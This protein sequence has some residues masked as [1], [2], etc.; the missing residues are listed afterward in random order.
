VRGQASA[1]RQGRG[2][3]RPKGERTDRAGP[4]PGDAG[5]DRR[6]RGA[7]RACV[8]LYPRSGSCDQDRTGEIRPGRDEWL[9]AALLLSVAVRSSELRQTCARGVS[10][11]PG[12]GRE[13]ENA[14]ANS[15]AGKRP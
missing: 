4:A 9:R 15:M 6:A 1:D 8:K 7:G 14:T 11:S 12:L 5:A 10:E 3:R 13:G 2:C